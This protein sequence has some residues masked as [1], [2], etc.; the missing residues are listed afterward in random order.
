[1]IFWNDGRRGFEEVKGEL[2]Q[3]QSMSGALVLWTLAGKLLIKMLSFGFLPDLRKKRV[4]ELFL[5]T[6]CA[7]RPSLIPAI[8]TGN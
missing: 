2:A 1:M 8:R 6:I 3:W 4:R 5:G 7:L